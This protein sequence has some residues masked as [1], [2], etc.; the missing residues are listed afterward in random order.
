VA[1]PDRERDDSLGQVSAEIE[2][3]EEMLEAAANEICEAGIT[4]YPCYRTMYDWR[5][6]KSWKQRLR[7]IPRANQDR[8]QCGQ[9]GP[10]GQ[11]T[12]SSASRGTS[13]SVKIGF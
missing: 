12:A 7:R 8:P 3:T 2:I 13:S 1:H 10:S 11:R 5:L 4:P 6:V 9:M